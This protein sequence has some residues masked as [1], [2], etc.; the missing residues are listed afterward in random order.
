MKKKTYLTP[1]LV[2]VE[3]DLNDVIATSGNFTDPDNPNPG[4]G[5]EEEPTYSRRRTNAI[6]D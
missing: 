6:W 5:D 2:L 1:E 4:T 3:M